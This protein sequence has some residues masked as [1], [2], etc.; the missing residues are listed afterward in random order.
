MSYLHM[1]VGEEARLTL[2]KKERIYRSK[3]NFDEVATVETEDGYEVQLHL[4]TELRKCF[5]GRN[6]GRSLTIKRLDS[7][8]SRQGANFWHV[9]WG[10]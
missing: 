7:N 6:E 2:I 8:F 1:E 5:A 10:E 9:K 3:W 4:D